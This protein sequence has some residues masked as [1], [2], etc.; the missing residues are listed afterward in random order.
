VAG[1]SV[2]VAQALHCARA[3]AQRQNS[4]ILSTPHLFIALTKLDG[5]TAAALRA[6]GQDPKHVRDGLRAALGQGQA[7]PGTEPK[8]TARAARNL[9]RAEE[10]AVAEG[11]SQVEERHLLAAILADDEDSL[12]L[13]VLRA[14]G[15]DVAVLRS[16]PSGSTPILDRVGRT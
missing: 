11:A 10:L 14:L 4:L 7:Q 15:V 13:R 8:P 3:E 12:T 16:G 1:F 9:Q 6:Q 2:P 5:D